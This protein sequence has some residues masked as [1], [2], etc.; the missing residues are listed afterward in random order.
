MGFNPPLTTATA[1]PGCDTAGLALHRLDRAQLAAVP[2]ID[3]L[4]IGLEETVPY[5]LSG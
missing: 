5:L 1:R 2:N 4:A 3:P